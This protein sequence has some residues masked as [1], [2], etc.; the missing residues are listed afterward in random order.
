MFSG[1]DVGL[2][3]EGRDIFRGKTWVF[4]RKLVMFSETGP[5]VCDPAS[6]GSW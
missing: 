6:G 2:S 4:L 5:D 3:E 1:K